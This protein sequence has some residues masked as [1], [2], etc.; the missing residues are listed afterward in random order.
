MIINMQII[1]HI[2]GIVYYKEKYFSLLKCT[3]IFISP[4]IKELEPLLLPIYTRLRPLPVRRHL[5]E[6]QQHTDGV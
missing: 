6:C 1:L 3:V 2:I 4:L 5:P